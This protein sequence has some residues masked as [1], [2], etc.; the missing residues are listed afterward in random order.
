MKHYQETKY[1]KVGTER[2]CVVPFDV[3]FQLKLL[4]ED[5]DFFISK[6][7]GD[8]KAWENFLDQHEQLINN[9]EVKKVNHN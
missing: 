4:K 3:K 2:I 9:E 5:N 6:I 1:R 8:I 7:K